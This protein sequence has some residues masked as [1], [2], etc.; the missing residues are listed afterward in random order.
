MHKFYKAR[1]KRGDTNVDDEARLLIKT[2]RS[3]Q[4]LTGRKEVQVLRHI[5]VLEGN[6]LETRCLEILEC[7]LVLTVPG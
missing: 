3:A 7:A 5:P 4:L 6:P 2:G 1:L